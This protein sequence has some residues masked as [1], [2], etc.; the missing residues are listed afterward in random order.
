MINLFIDTNIYLNFYHYTKDD[1]EELRKIIVLIEKKEVVLIFPHQ[2][3]DELLRNREV[4]LADSYN[5][6]K[7]KTISNNYPEYCS[8]F[9]ETK[10]LKQLSEEFQKVKSQLLDKIINHFNRS[11]L[12]ADELIKLIFSQSNKVISTKGLIT[13]SH[14]RMLIGNPPGKNNS[15]GDAIN[16]LILLKEIKQGNDLYLIS[17]DSDFSSKLDKTKFNPF[18]LEEW[19]KRKGSNLF[20][21]RSLSQFF[22]DKFPNIK[23]ALELEKEILIGKLFSSSSFRQSRELLQRISMFNDFSKDQVESYLNAAMINNQIFWISVDEDIN[24]L[25]YSFIDENIKSISQELYTTFKGKVPR[26]HKELSLPF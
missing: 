14:E 15:I 17:D 23:M 19:Q 8:Q 25:I 2:V 3:F 22:R 21:Y 16:W 10:R 4:K 20:F 12:L 13:D 6:I 26:L 18:L 24:H 5:E 11:S 9:D 7:S 1:L